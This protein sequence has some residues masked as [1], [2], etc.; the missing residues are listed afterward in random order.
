MKLTEKQKRFAD[1]YIR[2]GN[3]T[4]SYKRAGYACSNDNIAAVES[5]KLLRNPKVATHIKEIN[6]ELNKD[7][8][9]DMKEVK[10]F[11][12]NMMRDKENVK[13][14]DRLKA[15]GFLAKTNGAFL[16]RVE[17]SG[18]IEIDIDIEEEDD[19]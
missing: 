3:A 18:S 4:E 2:T 17:H 1:I 11:W 15:S 7:R 5:Y 8:I 19:G 14:T 13:D 16:D 6:K 10:Q 12:T 9:A